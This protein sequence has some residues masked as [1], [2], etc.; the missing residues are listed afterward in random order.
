VDVPIRQ[1]ET[2]WGTF[3]ATAVGNGT[4]RF[5]TRSPNAEDPEHR[6]TLHRLWY[7]ADIEMSDGPPRRHGRHFVDER[8]H[9][10]L[11]DVS[12]RVRRYPAGGTPTH[13]AL[14]AVRQRVL[15]EL[16]AW[17]RTPD[18][19]ALVME[20]T[21]YGLADRLQQAKGAEAVL[22]AALDRLIRAQGQLEAGAALSRDDEALV[23]H[24]NGDVARLLRG[25]S[26]PVA[27]DPI[28][29]P[30]AHEIAV[31]EAPGL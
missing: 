19:F 16:A 12:Y 6:V 23:V 7:S 14:A 9:V 13:N 31:P 17:L 8:W 2:E 1:L 25:A 20:G 11:T 18:G 3:Y 15:P 27:A 10:D 21:A 26:G 24:I 28:V 22:T 4:V 29:A 30:A 5:R